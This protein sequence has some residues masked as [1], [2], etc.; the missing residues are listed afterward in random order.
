MSLLDDAGDLPQLDPLTDAGQLVAL[1][2][3]ARRRGFRIG[4]YVKLGSIQLQVQDLR[5][6]EGRGVE[7]PPDKGPWAAAGFEEDS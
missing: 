5:Q 4:P 3:Y 2:E 1:L 6:T 7:L